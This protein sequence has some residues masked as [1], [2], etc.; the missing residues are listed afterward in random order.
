MKPHKEEPSLSLIPQ[1]A[2]TCIGVSPTGARGCP[3]RGPNLAGV[4]R[5]AAAIRGTSINGG[6]KS[7]WWGANSLQ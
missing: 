5:K 1:G 2:L 3:W 4:C 7:V 6:G